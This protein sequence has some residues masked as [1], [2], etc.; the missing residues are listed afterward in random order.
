MLHNRTRLGTLLAAANET[1]CTTQWFS[2]S[3]KLLSPSPV[4]KKRKVFLHQKKKK[5]QKKAVYSTRVKYKIRR[6]QY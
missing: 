5:K 6:G 4:P 1:R 2:T 3:L